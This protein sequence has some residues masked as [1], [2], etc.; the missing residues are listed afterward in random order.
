M[1]EQPLAVRVGALPATPDPL[2]QEIGMD[3]KERADKIV[4][5]GILRRYKD[6]DLY[7]FDKFPCDPYNAVTA[8]T[9]VSDW[10]VAGPLM[11]KIAAFGPDRFRF[12]NY[13]PSVNK[14]GFQI[15][16]VGGERCLEADSLPRAIIEA[17]V[18]AL[19]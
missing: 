19:S 11:E 17:C 14:Y 10:R 3:D 15:N 9:A 8:R 7:T 4:E 2:G 6:D 1:R 13:P 12:K 18:E 16:W 5:L